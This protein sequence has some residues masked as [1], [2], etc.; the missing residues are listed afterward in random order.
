MI[1]PK[2]VEKQGSSILL[3]TGPVV[4]AIGGIVAIIGTALPWV[5][6]VGLLSSVDAFGLSV[7]VLNGW[8]DATQERL[9]AR[10]ADRHP[11]RRSASSSR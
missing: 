3:G 11:G 2:V 5:Q 6:T 1:Q 8:D 9:R 10:D 4:G 7:R